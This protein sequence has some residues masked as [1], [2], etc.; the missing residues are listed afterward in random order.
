MDDDLD[1]A[2]TYDYEQ[3]LLCQC[4]NPFDESSDDTF[5]AAW[6]AERKVCWACS[7]RDRTA[8]IDRKD[9]K[10]PPHGT[11]YLVRNRAKDLPVPPSQ[12]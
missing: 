4:G 8:E 2:L 9:G 7:A 11:K 6:I 3:S 10:R 1:A 12:Q 5:R